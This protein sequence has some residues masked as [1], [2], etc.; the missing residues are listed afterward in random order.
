MY[1]YPVLSTSLAERLPIILKG[2]FTLCPL[3]NSRNPLEVLL[4][5]PNHHDTY[6]IQPQTQDLW[7]VSLLV[8]TFYNHYFS[9]AEKK[10][11]NLN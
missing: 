2:N 3:L 1:Y 9:D 7:A 5:Y 8:Q 6:S 4:K 10:M 11:Q